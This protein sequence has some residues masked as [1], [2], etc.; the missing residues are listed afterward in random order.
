MRPR[1][2]LARI[3]P[4]EW[5]ILVYTGFVS[6]LTLI[7]YNSIQGAMGYMAE[8]VLWVLLVLAMG[9]FHN[10]Q[11]PI[12]RF[13]RH[14]YFIIFFYFF[15]MQVGVYGPAIA[16]Q[17]YDQ[18]ILNFELWVFGS[19]PAIWLAKSFDSVF[20][21][22]LLMMGYFSYFFLGFALGA[23]LYFQK[24]KTPF[25]QYAFALTTTYLLCY[26][27]YIF[28][29]SSGPCWFLPEADVFEL[30]G[31]FFTNMVHSV[32]QKA[33]S[34]AAFPSAHV[35][36]SFVVLFYAFRFQR[37]IFWIIIPFVPLL[38]IG[39]VYGRFHFAVDAIAGIVAAILITGLTFTVWDRVWGRKVEYQSPPN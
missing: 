10:I 24:N 29:P 21:L 27:F 22:E 26:A 13:I 19:V 34:S 16:G 8:H 38:T 9:L 28:F 11:N 3:L 30:K 20:L 2:F 39:T 18:T 15:F 14:W 6:I 33:V 36:T 32:H 37:L 1:D 23:P 7:Y 5:V 12:I 31:L 4:V 17:V 35:T 25:H